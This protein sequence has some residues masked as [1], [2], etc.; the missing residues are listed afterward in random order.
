[1]WDCVQDHGD[2]YDKMY[3]VNQTSDKK[4]RTERIHSMK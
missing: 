4:M 1:M 3:E 2:S